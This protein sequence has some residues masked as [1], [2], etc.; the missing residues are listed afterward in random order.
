[1]K[2]KNFKSGVCVTNKGNFFTVLCNRWRCLAFL[3]DKRGENTESSGLIRRIDCL[4][5]TKLRPTLVYFCSLKN[6]YIAIRIHNLHPKLKEE[7]E[8]QVHFDLR[9]IVYDTLTCSS[10]RF[11]DYCTFNN[12]LCVYLNILRN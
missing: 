7:V 11:F 4:S 8:N 5:P 6:V 1:M 12:N 10:V 2:F 9:F 3:Y